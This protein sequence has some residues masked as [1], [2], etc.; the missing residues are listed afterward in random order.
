L[1]IRIWFFGLK[2]TTPS[3]VE[4]LQQQMEAA[5]KLQPSYLEQCLHDRKYVLN[6]SW[7]VQHHPEDFK[8]VHQK[9]GDCI[10]SNCSHSVSGF[11]MLSVAFNVCLR[12]HLKHYVACEYISGGT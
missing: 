3:G 11:S 5:F 1:S 9:P 6:P 10:L 2:T 12:S 4:I 8:I 7:W